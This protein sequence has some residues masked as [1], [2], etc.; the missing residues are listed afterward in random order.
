MTKQWKDKTKQNE[1]KKSYKYLKVGE[2][3]YSSQN[4]SGTESEDSITCFFN[5]LN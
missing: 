1:K 4:L 2:R 3:I 5:K